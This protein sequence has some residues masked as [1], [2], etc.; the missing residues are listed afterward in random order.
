MLEQGAARARTG[1]PRVHALEQLSG[2]HR[3]VL[4]VLELTNEHED[5]RSCHRGALRG[6]RLADDDATAE[7]P[8]LSI[9]TR[10]TPN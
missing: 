2:S 5:V 7:L 9:A 4:A 8:K 6:G 3:I 1:K 10:Q